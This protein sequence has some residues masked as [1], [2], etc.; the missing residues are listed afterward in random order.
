MWTPA[1]GT[2][3]LKTR[4]GTEAALEFL[5]RLLADEVT[6]AALVKPPYADVLGYIGNMDAESFFSKD[7]LA[8]HTYWARAWAARSLAY[9]G[10]EDATPWLLDALDDPHWRVRMNALQALGRLGS[11]GHE[12]ELSERLT[13]EHERVRGAAALAL[14]R[15]GNEFAIGPLREALEDENEAVRR[16]ADR[17]LAKIE[18]R[19]RQAF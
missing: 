17:A 14:G 13:D 5:T 15:T 1:R 12:E 9:L 18:A 4:F 8:A 11:E 19:L 16:Q 3:Q 6:A 7:V 10:D 2:A